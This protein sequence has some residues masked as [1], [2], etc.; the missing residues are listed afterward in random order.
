MEHRNDAQ[1]LT[2]ID[3]HCH[4]SQA[5]QTSYQIWHNLQIVGIHAVLALIRFYIYAYNRGTVSIMSICLVYT[6]SFPETTEHPRRSGFGK[7]ERPAQSLLQ[8]CDPEASARTFPPKSAWSTAG[9][10]SQKKNTSTDFYH[11]VS[12]SVNHKFPV[13]FN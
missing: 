4:C 12:Y 13:R 9:E 5:R 10:I 1:M 3:V 8:S 6:L 2:F 7:Q 11:S